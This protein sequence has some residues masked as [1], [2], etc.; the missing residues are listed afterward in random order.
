VGAV[1]GVRAVGRHVDVVRAAEDE[2]GVVEPAPGRHLQEDGQHLDPPAAQGGGEHL[3]ASHPEHQIDREGLRVAAGPLAGHRRAGPEPVVPV[4]RHEDL[5]VERPLGRV[6]HELARAEGVAA[7]RPPVVELGMARRARR[8][9]RP[10]RVPGRGDRAGLRRRG[11]TGP[12][13]EVDPDGQDREEEQGKGDPHERILSDAA[14]AGTPSCSS[15]SA[16]GTC[17]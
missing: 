10:L 3:D 11:L 17:R 5:A 2:V 15:A 12:Y 7:L 16:A 8:A 14:T 4:A 1:P 9:P 13:Q 6:R